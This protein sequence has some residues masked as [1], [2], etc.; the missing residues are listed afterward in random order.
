MDEGDWGVF[1]ETLIHGLETQE[2]QD[3]HWRY[4]A[5]G[6][7]MDYDGLCT[8]MCAAVHLPGCVLVQGVVLR[9]LF[10]PSPHVPSCTSDGFHRLCSRLIEGASNAGC[11]CH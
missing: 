5:C 4:L 8:T 3:G 1:D 6:C 11:C 2:L 10:H 9:V 7:L